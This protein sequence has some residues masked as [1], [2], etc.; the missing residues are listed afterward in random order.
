[1]EIGLQEFADAVSAGG[2]VL[3]VREVPEYEE[4]HVPGAH[5][6]PLSELEARYGEVPTDHKVYVI[7]AAGKRSLMA[8]EFLQAQGA[9][10]VSVSAGTI[11][12]IQAGGPVTPGSQP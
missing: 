4:G 3:D 8:T 11:G 10:V 2:Y 7:C 12:W 9:D 6:L 5:L 1:M